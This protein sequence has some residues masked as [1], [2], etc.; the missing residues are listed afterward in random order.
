MNVENAFIIDSYSGYYPEIGRN[1]S[2][3][4]NL[5]NRGVDENVYP[6]PRTITFGIQVSL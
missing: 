5:F 3:G 1:V 6:V 4:D 2:R